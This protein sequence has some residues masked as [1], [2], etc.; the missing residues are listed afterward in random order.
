MNTPWAGIAIGAVAA[1]AAFGCGGSAG[2]GAGTSM[3]G[4]SSG[5]S[6]GRDGPAQGPLGAQAEGVGVSWHDSSKER[7]VGSSETEPGSNWLQIVDGY[8]THRRLGEAV[9]LSRAQ[10]VPFALPEW[11]ACPS[12]HP[13]ASPHRGDVY[14][15]TYG[16]IMQNLDVFAYE[17][18]FDRTRGAG[19][20]ISVAPGPLAPGPSAELA[21]KWASA[22]RRCSRARGC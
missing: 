10:G 17:N 13:P 21:S 12:D 19:R 6:A 11:A 22:S 9:E 1:A 8:S 3:G 16:F 18:V 15:F 5:G 20:S 4:S 2:A 7:I 14:R